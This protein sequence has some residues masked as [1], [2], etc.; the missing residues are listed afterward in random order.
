MEQ[1]SQQSKFNQRN[2]SPL[3]LLIAIKSAPIASSLLYVG[4]NQDPNRAREMTPQQLE[5]THQAL[6]M[7]SMSYLTQ[8]Y[9]GSPM[10]EVA[11]SLDEELKAQGK[12]LEKILS[13]ANSQEISSQ[14]M[15]LLGAA[16]KT[17]VVVAYGEDVDAFIDLEKR[18]ALD[19][20]IASSQLEEPVKSIYKGISEVSTVT[21]L[22]TAQEVFGQLPQKYMA[23]LPT[24][25]NDN[26]G[27]TGD[28]RGDRD[29]A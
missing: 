6:Y 2:A 17:S 15:E 23:M 22:Y 3:E 25:A 26:Y 11:N 21:A 24:P 8:L 1:Q 18:N 14:D 16:Y 19:K 28:A 5:A 7:A 10:E 9:S 4:I 13:L 29:A 20:A 27:P 12:S